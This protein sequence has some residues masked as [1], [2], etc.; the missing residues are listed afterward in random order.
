VIVSHVDRSI[1]DSTFDRTESL[2]D[3]ELVI[4]SLTGVQLLG[5]PDSEILQFFERELGLPDIDEDALGQ[6]LSIIMLTSAEQR[7]RCAGAGKISAPLWSFSC[8]GGSL[9]SFGIVLLARI[10]GVLRFFPRGCSF[11]RTRLAS[12]EAGPLSA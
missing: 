7:I 11:N 1:G 8:V 3:V 9:N 2:T 4:L 6:L 12:C 5:V 10:A